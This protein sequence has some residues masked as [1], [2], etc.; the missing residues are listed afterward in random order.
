MT[1]I[2]AFAPVFDDLNPSVGG[3]VYRRIDSDA[4]LI[5]WCNVP[6][7]DTNS[8]LLFDYDDNRVTFRVS[9]GY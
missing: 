3:G 8:N 7:F 2:R 5:T 6:E 1:G 9:V 4:L